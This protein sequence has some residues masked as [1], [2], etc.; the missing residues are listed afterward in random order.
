M[1]C[2][3]EASYNSTPQDSAYT[4][5]SRWLV[6]IYSSVCLQSKQAYLVS[7]LLA[8]AQLFDDLFIAGCIFFREIRQVAAA[9]ADHLEQAA[10]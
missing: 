7:N 5:T 6:T 3:A 1:K 8:Q 10:T 2:G 4:Q 9:F